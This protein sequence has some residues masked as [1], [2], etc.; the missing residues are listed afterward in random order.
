V[1]AGSRAG[2]A[3]TVWTD[4]S[5]RRVPPPDQG[6]SPAGAAALAAFLA[7]VGTALIVLAAASLA[8]GAVDRR[9]MAA[10]DADWRAT[11]PQW[12]GRR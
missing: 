7:A 10:W 5:G 4:A 9:R 6:S 8:R 3:V 1:P 11:G 2:T 12:S